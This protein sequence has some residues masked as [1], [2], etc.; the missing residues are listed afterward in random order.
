[1]KDCPDCEAARSNR[2]HAIYRAACK[3]CSARMLAASPLF[4]KA[5]LT[6]KQFAEYR[7]ALDAAGVTHEQVKAAA[8]E[9]GPCR[10]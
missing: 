3:G 6:G 2:L 5:R 4:W 9:V 7:A 1:M 8:M 10:A